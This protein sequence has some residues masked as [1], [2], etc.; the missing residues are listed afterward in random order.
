MDRRT[1]AWIVW[2]STV[3]VSF[4]VLE[5]V[6]YKT[7][8]MLTLTRALQRWIGVEP[9]CSYGRVSP[10]AFVLFGAWLAW[11]L[12]QVEREIAEAACPSSTTL[13]RA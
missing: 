9:R 3:A 2:L 12:A 7:G 11:H 13:R 6:A 4:G 8:K 1:A 5:G 10:L